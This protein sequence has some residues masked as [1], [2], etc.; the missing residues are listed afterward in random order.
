[1]NYQIAFWVAALVAALALYGAWRAARLAVKTQ[2]YNKRLFVE[3]LTSHRIR[4]KALA[5]LPEAT[6]ALITSDVKN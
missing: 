5:E 4:D 3:V 1:M 6:R 2:D